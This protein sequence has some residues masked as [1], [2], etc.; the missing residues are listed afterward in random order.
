MEF[1]RELKD[2]RYLLLRKRPYLASILMNMKA[3]PVQSL[4]S[5]MAVDMHWNLYYNPQ[6][7]PQLSPQQ[8]SAVLYHEV[9][10]LLAAHHDRLRHYEQGIANAGG[11]LAINSYLHDEGFDLP[12]DGLFPR[13]FGLP[14][15]KSAEWYCDNIASLFEV[16]MLQVGSGCGSSGS[17]DG[18]GA[19]G[20]AGSDS[21]G[22]SS[23][24]EGDGDSSS[25][26]GSG[27]SSKDDG[28]SSSAGSDS[29]DGSAG[30]KADDRSTDR[31]GKKRIT[32]QD[33]GSC[34][35]GRPRS[36][37]VDGGVPQA[38]QKAVLKEVAE[39]VLR[40]KSRGTLPDH[41]VRWA[42]DLL[43]SRIDWRTLLRS[44]VQGELDSLYSRVDYS[45]RGRN[46]RQGMCDVI[47]PVLRA[48]TPKVALIIDTSGSMSSTELGIALA[49]VKGALRATR[50]LEVYSAD[51]ELQTA[52][53]VFSHRQVKLV[54]GGGTSMK[55]AV[56]QVLKRR[57][58][59]DLV[60]IIT[61][62]FTDWPEPAKGVHMV[63]ALTAHG[64][65][66]PPHHIRF[67]DISRRD[68]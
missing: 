48:P 58:R 4:P 2:A 53:R 40:E 56:E 3:Y 34:A 50:S 29:D 10:H 60:V 28:D 46:R 42:E 1:P 27:S 19:G 64:G 62:G 57:A 22:G 15:L 54:G 41:I 47:L 37:E 38:V 61:D 36:Y 8:L 45:W 9:W 31:H 67:I 23:N 20:E 63:A 49:E 30:D 16:R 35:D 18:G 32:V 13:D 5:V 17:G 24:G 11:D 7:L 68:K 14:E 21:D 66:P 26:A 51:A 33:H 44:A 25:G 6:L 52:Q 39:A 12:P 55:R 59:P 43:E 65:T